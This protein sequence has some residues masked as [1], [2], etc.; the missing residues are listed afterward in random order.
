MGINVLLPLQAFSL[1]ALTVELLNGGTRLQSTGN[2]YYS[3]D[4][5]AVLFVLGLVFL[6]IYY[7]RYH[8]MRN[9]INEGGCLASLRRLPAAVCSCLG[10]CSGRCGGETP[11]KAAP[12]LDIMRNFLREPNLRYLQVRH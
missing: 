2:M 8:M 4:I 11:L 6:L 12:D 7:K 3:W 10:C 9:L 1:V 5:R